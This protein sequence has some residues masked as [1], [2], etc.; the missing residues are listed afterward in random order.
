MLIEQIFM[1]RSKTDVLFLYLNVFQ[2]D[3]AAA[4]GASAV[5]IY[6]DPEQHT[7]NQNTPLYGHVSLQTTVLDPF[8]Q[9]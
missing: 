6:P 4:K 1:L 5:L 3:N 7:Y 9:P 8:E 2:V